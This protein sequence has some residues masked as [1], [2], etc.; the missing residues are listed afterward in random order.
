MYHN[1]GLQDNCIKGFTCEYLPLISNYSGALKALHNL[2]IS[3]HHLLLITHENYLTCTTVCVNIYACIPHAFENI[4]RVICEM[5]QGAQ[6]SMSI[7]VN[8]DVSCTVYA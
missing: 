5:C 7:S 4:M 2:L 3:V 1:W 6:K 8:L